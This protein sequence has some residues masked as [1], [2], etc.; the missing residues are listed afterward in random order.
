MSQL[1][2]SVEIP[3]ELYLQLMNYFASTRE[4]QLLIQ[5]DKINKQEE[6]KA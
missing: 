1:G 2:N 3:K 6:E 5:L 4:G